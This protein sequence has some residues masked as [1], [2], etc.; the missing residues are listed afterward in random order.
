MI[1][2]NIM[3]LL[4]SIHFFCLVPACLECSECN[5][6]FTC[7]Y[8][9]SMHTAVHQSALMCDKCPAQFR[10]ASGLYHHTRTVHMKIYK[11]RCHVEL[12]SKQFEMKE[13]YAAHM[14]RHLN[15]PYVCSTCSKSYSSKFALSFHLKHC[16]ISKMKKC[17]QCDQTFRR[18]NNLTEHVQYKHGND[19]VS[20]PC[21]KMYKWPKT[22]ARH[23]KQCTV[24]MQ[25]SQT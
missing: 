22:L 18:K 14:N 13:H 23:Q 8:L 3:L 1:M 6:K 16:G 2:H 4:T 15:T 24:L 7:N 10:S 11:H 9:L 5:K 12:C 17:D 25:L 19:R 21:G 20:C